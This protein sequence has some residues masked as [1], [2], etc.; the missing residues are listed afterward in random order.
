M[1]QEKLVEFFENTIPFN[2]HLGIQVESI[3][4]ELCTIK[5]PFQKEWIGDPKRPALHGGLL[6]TLADTAGGLA[7]FLR[8]PNPLVDRTS[9]VDLRVDYLRHGL[10]EDLY[11]DASVLRLGNRV[12]VTEMICRQGASR[13]YIAA[14]CRGVYNIHRSEA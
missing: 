1:N 10:L 14:K 11:C 7:V 8:L 13:D 9:T 3:T 2:R 5:I 6:S 12:A 4:E